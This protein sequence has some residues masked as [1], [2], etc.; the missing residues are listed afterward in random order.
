MEIFIRSILFVVLYILLFGISLILNSN[1]Y[2]MSFVL[3]IMST[4]VYKYLEMSLL[5]TNSRDL[6][7]SKL[8]S[9]ICMILFIILNAY[10]LSDVDT[11]HV[12]FSLFTFYIGVILFLVIFLSVVYIG[13]CM[14]ILLIK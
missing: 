14:T 2:G 3:L 11:Q 8:K 4:T 9:L 5:D 7:I 1:I 6:R 13:R 12:L 10:H